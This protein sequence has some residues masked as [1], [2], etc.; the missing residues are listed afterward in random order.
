MVLS[1]SYTQTLLHGPQHFLCTITVR[2]SA[3]LAH[4][5][6]R[7]VLYTYITAWEQSVVVV[8]RASTPVALMNGN[9]AEHT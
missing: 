8:K 3:S 9:D 4:M 2:S 6:C 5:H 1:V 7:M